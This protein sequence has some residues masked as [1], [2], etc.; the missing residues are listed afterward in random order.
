[1]RSPTWSGNGRSRSPPRGSG[2]LG[3]GPRRR[4]GVGRARARVASGRAADAEVDASW[5]QRL[6]HPEL[7]GDLEWTVVG[8]HDAARSH[9]DATGLA[10]TAPMRISGPR[11]R[12]ASSGARPAST[13]G[14]RD[15]RRL[16]RAEGSPGSPHQASGPSGSDPG[17]S[18]AGRWDGRGHR[19]F[20]ATPAGRPGPRAGDAAPARLSRTLG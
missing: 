9:P 8:Q 14:S 20:I 6:Q 19:E 4:R 16:A 3:L 1:M 2:T 7:L 13:G 15:G 10:A 11:R 18:G 12:P 17:R 5:M